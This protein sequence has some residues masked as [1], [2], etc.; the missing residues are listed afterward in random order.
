MC[1]FGSRWIPP[2]R[3][4]QD[5]AFEPCLC[6]DSLFPSQLR[7]QHD[8]IV[9]RLLTQSNQGR[10][11]LRLCIVSIA[12]W[13]RTLFKGN[14]M[15]R[16]PRATRR[17]FSRTSI[18][19][20]TPAD[21]WWKPSLIWI[22]KV[23]KALVWDSWSYTLLSF[24]YTLISS[25]VAQNPLLIRAPVSKTCLDK[26]V[27]RALFTSCALDFGRACQSTRR[28]EDYMQDFRG[29]KK[30]VIRNLLCLVAVHHRRY[31]SVRPHGE[32]LWGC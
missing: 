14:T 25:A 23:S 26:D 22:L 3:S 13:K 32:L 31:S 10:F 27:T 15:A 21:T 24:S 30:A 7:R 20:P 18:C 12:F 17:C 5:Y 4:E 9:Q 28:S 6:T 19:C 8:S 1:L 2:S 16:L 11:S 29:G